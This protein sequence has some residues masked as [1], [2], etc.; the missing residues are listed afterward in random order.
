MKAPKT[1]VAVSWDDMTGEQ[2]YA[3][4]ARR[5]NNRKAGRAPTDDGVHLVNVEAAI[6]V[7]RSTAGQPFDPSHVVYTP[8][9]PSRWLPTDRRVVLPWSCLVSDN[10]RVSPAVRG[11][12]AVIIQTAAYRTAK[13]EA[14]AIV[15]AALV[16]GPLEGPVSI[17]AEFFEPNRS[18]GRDISNYAKLVHDAL[19]GFAYVD[20]KQIDEVRWIRGPVCVDAPRLVITVRPLPSKGL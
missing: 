10:Q 9:S 16:Y 4:A 11:R 5:N 6:A 1:P 18:R 8:S 3:E 2:R 7:R 14:R 15:A 17:L 13:R 20:D 19:S 12:R